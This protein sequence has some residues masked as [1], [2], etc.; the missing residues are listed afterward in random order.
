MNAFV[1]TLNL[2][3]PDAEAALAPELVVK[4]A[5]TPG[6]W[7]PA[8]FAREQI[9]SLVRRVFLQ[10]FPH[11]MKHVVFTAVE[12]DHNIA[13]ICQKVGDALGAQVPGA[14]CLVDAGPGSSRLTTACD[15]LGRLPSATVA[16]CVKDRTTRLSVN[17]WL[18]QAAD[19]LS[20][21]EKE[22]S[23]SWLRHRL[24][25]LRREFDYTVIH[26]PAV[27]TF[28]LTSLLAHLSDGVVLV[29][30]AERT[31]RIAAQHA[32]DVLHAAQARLIGTVLDQRQFPIPQAVYRRL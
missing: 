1:E 13:P 15:H 26:A 16:K 6:A 18:L 2:S 25:E 10:G 31:R 14:I 17:V 29:L 28:S 19:F 21:R 27:A 20:T 5:V 7:E 3:P 24:S 23:A 9:S 30:N 4:P 12:S 11:P 22:C 8:I 32:R